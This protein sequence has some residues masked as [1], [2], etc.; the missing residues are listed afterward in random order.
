MRLED[1]FDFQRPDDIRIKGHRIGIE[2]VLDAFIAGGLQPREIVE[3]YPALSLEEVYATVLYYL[4]NKESVGAYY[5]AWVDYCRE[6]RAA[7][8]AS[9]PESIRRLAALKAQLA[10]LSESERRAR[11]KQIAAERQAEDVVAAEVA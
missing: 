1:Y 7:Y 2:T 5:S 9:R 10:E 3:Q 6:S 11:L 4:H 8:D